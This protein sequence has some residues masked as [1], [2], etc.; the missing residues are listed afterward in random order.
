MPDKIQ[1]SDLVAKIQN[2]AITRAEIEMLFTI[3][4]SR[5]RPFAPA[6]TLNFD[7][8]DAEGIER[9]AKLA[10]PALAAEA[11]RASRSNRLG[12]D[13]ADDA[14]IVAEGDSW[15]DHWFIDE[16]MDGYSRR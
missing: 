9:S 15:F 6:L 13:V 12:R 3:D 2:N 8:I 10:A 1:F 16:V 4:E 5:S 14:P 11:G 7:A